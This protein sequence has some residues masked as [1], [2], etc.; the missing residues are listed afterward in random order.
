MI[1]EK[2]PEIEFPE[3]KDGITV[4][5]QLTSEDLRLIR[6]G[7]IAYAKANRSMG[8]IFDVRVSDAVKMRELLKRMLRRVK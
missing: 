5:P 6:E 2:F 4:R 1:G 7:F 3:I 8:D